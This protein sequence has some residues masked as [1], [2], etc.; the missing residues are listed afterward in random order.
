NVVETISRLCEEDGKDI[1]LACGGKLLTILLNDDMIDEMT[2]NRFPVVLGTGIPLFSDNLR[3]P[4]WNL[5]NSA[6]YQ[7][8]ITQTTY[9][10]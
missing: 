9:I 1:W 2:I 5:K 4:K 7:N 10:K 3:G 8:G 6:C